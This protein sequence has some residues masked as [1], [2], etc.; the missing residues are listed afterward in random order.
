MSN[1]SVASSTVR[2]ANKIYQNINGYIFVD[3]DNQHKPS[4]VKKINDLLNKDEIIL[5]ERNF[6]KLNVPKR[7]RFGNLFSKYYFKLITGV[8]IPDTQTGLRGVPYKYTN[9]L[10]YT[11][12]DRYDYEMNFLINTANDKIPFKTI[13]I[14]TIYDNNN[15]SHFDPIKDSIRIY[16]EPIKYIGSS[17]SSFIIDILL[18]SIFNSL[19]NLVFVANVMARLISGLYNYFMNKYWC[20]KSYDKKSFIKYLCL[21]ITQMLIS[22]SFVKLT[23]L[24]S[25]KYI[26][27]FKII[28]DLGIFV[29]NFLIQKRYVFKGE[30]LNEKQL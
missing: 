28:I 14:T 27:I 2:K 25:C 8:S 23:S 16:K 6:N 11:E 17:L 29:V 26:V 18:F 21:F 24:I 13:E 15:E 10:L 30:K 1:S 19:F 9:Y 4:D 12:G 7:N 20:F 5:G 22:S 3:G